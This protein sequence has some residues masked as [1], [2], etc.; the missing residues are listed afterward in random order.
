[1]LHSQQG[2]RLWRCWPSL[3]GDQD[4]RYVLS[5]N[6]IWCTLEGAKAWPIIS[7]KEEFGV[8]MCEGAQFRCHSVLASELVYLGNSWDSNPFIQLEALWCHKEQL[9]TGS[10]LPVLELE[11]P[12]LLVSFWC[13]FLTVNVDRSKW[14]CV[15]Q[16]HNLLHG[17]RGSR[18]SMQAD[19][20]E[21]A[22]FR[23]SLL[24]NRGRVPTYHG[25]YYG[26]HL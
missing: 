5:L 7:N 3:R 26:W 24:W 10:S 22:S 13:L 19:D 16:C 9:P 15:E 1:M 8:W 6:H 21:T 14:T 23:S 4:Y 18:D 17:D 2:N 25:L 20:R 11:P 12:S